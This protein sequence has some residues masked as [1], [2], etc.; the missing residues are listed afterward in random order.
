MTS[1]TGKN[2]HDWRR[3]VI[4]GVASGAMAAGLLAG[5]GVSTA[6]AEPVES[7]T[8]D[9]CAKTDPAGADTAPVDDGRPSARHHRQG[10]R[11]G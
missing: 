1:Q 4:G 5:F 3:A 6:F 11:H 10:L 8:G 9:D 2:R 7:C